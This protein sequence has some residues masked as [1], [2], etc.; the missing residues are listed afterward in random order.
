MV[1]FLPKSVVLHI[2]QEQVKNSPFDDVEGIL[3][4]DSLDSALNQPRMTI[5]TTGGRAFLHPTIFDMAAAYGFHL[6][7]NHAF[8]SCN[9]RT[10]Y[11][12]MV[13][14]LRLNGFDIIVNNEEEHRDV[15]VAVAEGKMDKQQLADWLR[16]ITRPKGS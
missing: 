15:M 5:S 6:C 8:V 10:A 7:Q 13:T 3:N 2:Q 14:F 9:K 1:L 11:S 12:T 16:T 4:P